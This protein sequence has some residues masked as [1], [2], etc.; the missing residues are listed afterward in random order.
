MKNVSVINEQGHVRLSWEYDG[1]E[2]LLIK[3]DTIEISGLVT[4]A[5]I[6][7]ST[8]TSYIDT[9]AQAHVKPRSYIVQID[10]SGTSI[11]TAIVSTYHLTYDY[12]SCANEIHLAWTDLQDDY[13]TTNEWNPKKFTIYVNEEGNLKEFTAEAS[14]NSFTVE[15]IKENTN[16]TFKIGVEWEETDSMGFSN[17]VSPFTEMSQSPDYINAIYATVEGENTHLKFEIAP[18]SELSTYI[19]LYSSSPTGSYDTLETINTTDFEVIT[20]H[21][22]SNPDTEITYYKLVAIN[23]CGNMSTQS[24]IINNI[25]LTVEREENIQ[26]L[27]WNY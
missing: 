18:N 8:I 4:I 19:L 5:K 9:N 17:P 11:G 14:E 26:S 1:T 22:N 27:S 3:R 23:N 12:D 20:T 15:D 6:E 2:N 21:E 7:D 24:D 13:L 10:R 16:Y 25:L